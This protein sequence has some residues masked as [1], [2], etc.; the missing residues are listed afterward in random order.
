MH[1]RQRRPQGSRRIPG[2]RQVSGKKEIEP[3]GPQTEAA[4]DAQEK[5]H[6][7]R[8]RDIDQA[9]EDGK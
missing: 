8:Q 9:N 1:P 2:I 7:Q 4:K 3:A 5:R 6:E